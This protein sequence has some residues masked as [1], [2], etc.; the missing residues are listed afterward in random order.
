MQAK[1][2]EEELNMKKHRTR[3]ALPSFPGI[4]A[5]ALSLCWTVS[6]A[7][8]EP[9]ATRIEH[10]DKE[11]QNWLT[12]YG[13]YRAWSYSPLDQISRANV[14]QLVPV[15]AFPTGG[16]NG[17]EAAPLVSHVHETISNGQT[18]RPECWLGRVRFS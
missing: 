9:T 12:F 6:V 2:A 7:S 14:K 4:L 16:Q 18:P 13:N 10:A 17:L 15:W 3:G 8:Q 5:T 1:A 11:P